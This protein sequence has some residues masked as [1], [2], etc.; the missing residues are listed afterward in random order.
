MKRFIFTKILLFVL[1]LTPVFALQLNSQMPQRGVNQVRITGWAD[2][3]HYLIQTFDAEKNL[4]IKSVD[5]KIGKST[6]VPPQKSE[7][8]ILSESLPQGVTLGF[9]DVV[10]PDMNSIIIYKG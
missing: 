6:I 5:V 3:S 7:R 9:N 10:S 1:L 2:D 4:V 8:D